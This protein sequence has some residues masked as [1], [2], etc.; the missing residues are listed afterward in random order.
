MLTATLSPTEES[1]LLIE[2]GIQ[3]PRVVRHSS[4]R[5]NLQYNVIDVVVPADYLREISH[6][7]SEVDKFDICNAFTTYATLKLIVDKLEDMHVGCTADCIIVYFNTTRCLETFY[8][9]IRRSIDDDAGFVNYFLTHTD[10]DEA[11]IHRLRKSI[12]DS[13]NVFG[14]YYRTL[15]AAKAKDYLQQ[16]RDDNIRIML[17]TSGFGVYK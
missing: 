10:L 8:K 1:C 13:I 3:W 12:Q 11:D 9:V 14:I 5:P 4:E 7:A 16:Y 15:E 17:A 6:S 2:Y